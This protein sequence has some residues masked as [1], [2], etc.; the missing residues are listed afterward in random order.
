MIGSLF[1]SGAMQREVDT[2]LSYDWD[3]ERRGRPPLGAM[4]PAS[5][6]SANAPARVR[7]GSER[8]YSSNM[9]EAVKLSRSPLS[10]LDLS[11]IARAGSN[12]RGVT[13]PV[14]PDCGGSQTSS[15][16]GLPGDL[17]SSV[18]VS[19]SSWEGDSE[20][21]GVEAGQEARR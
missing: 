15:I 6:S 19:G 10:D 16:A 9:T 8:R 21:R 12:R 2:V 11:S 7:K 4:R 20:E 18:S 3:T 5:A 17:L 13:A 14:A 1:L